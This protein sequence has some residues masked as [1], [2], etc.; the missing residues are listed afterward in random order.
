MP[1]GDD[2]ICTDGIYQYSIPEVEDAEAYEWELSPAE[3]GTLTVT[4]NNAGLETSEDWTGDF[5]LKARATNMCGNGEWSD[6]FNG[7]IYLTPEVFVLEGGGGFCADGEGVEVTLSGSQEGVDYQLYLEGDPTDNIVAGTGSA[8]SFGMITETGMYSAEGYTD[9]CTAIMQEQV[10][11]F[12]YFPPLEPGT[13]TGPETACN[14]TTSTYESTGSD[15]ADSYTWI[16]SP[17]EAGTLTPNGLEASVEWSTEF[18]GTASVSL[19][20]SNECGDGYAS[21]EL[22]VSVEGIPNPVVEGLSMVCDFDV[23]DYTVAENEGSTYTWE[24]TGGTIVDG[25]DTYM[26]T[27]EWGEAGDGTVTVTEVTTAGCEGASETFDVMIDD[28][29]D[30]NEMG[31]VSDFTVYPNPATD[32]LTVE[33][34]NNSENIQQ[35]MLYNHLGQKVYQSEKIT[36]RGNQKLEINI[37]H[38]SQGI[39]FVKLSDGSSEIITEKVIKK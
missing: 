37:S 24:V 33:Y 27:V 32:R 20:G 6:E 30:I 11:V 31:T 15:D 5:T 29:T 14:N 9:N 1:S 17:E 22:D 16:L 7:S 8:I 13:P 21:Q 39:Y 19:Y 35:L 26:V 4:M 12:N 2:V 23:T 28:C 34:N 38:L 10:D 18:T 25:Q 3:A 36:A